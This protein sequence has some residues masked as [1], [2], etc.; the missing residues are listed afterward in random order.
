MSARILSRGR[1]SD[2]LRAR[3]RRSRRR[4]L[5][6]LVVLALLSLFALVYGLRQEAVRVSR[7]QVFGADAP[8]AAIAEADMRGDYLGVIPRD[9][10]FLLPLARIRADILAA[11]PAIAAVSL[12]RSGFTGL[13]IRAD[14][15]VPVARWCGAAPS[16][17][18]ATSSLP[19]AAGCY[20]F[21][22][23]GFV[24]ATTS[25][26]LPV[27]PFVL[28]EPLSSS[29]SPVG[30]TL[31]AASRLPAAFDFARQLGSTF[32]ASVSAVV[33]AN[34]EANDELASGTRVTYVLGDEQNAFTALVSARGQ[35]NLAD[36]S[37]EYVDLR[38]DGKIYLKKKG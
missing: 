8:L 29:T 37:L 20:L 36:G 27:N 12:S 19:D 7:I 2:R 1:G 16:G 32:G 5:G 38:F 28:Y 35:L 23:A 18:L 6:A 9:S 22:A 21:D 26:E 4:A 14:R 25:A 30:A 15:R 33:I 3:R 10:T 11:Y 31:S 13:S 24:F 17:A 34:G